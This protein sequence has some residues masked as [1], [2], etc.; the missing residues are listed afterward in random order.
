MRLNKIIIGFTTI[1]FAALIAISAYAAG[2]P[3]SLLQSVADNMIA[4]LKQNQA[5]LKTKPGIVYNLAQQ[6]VVPYANLDE[7]S[8]RVLPRQTWNS[9][10]PAQKAE[11]KKNFT[12]TLIRTYASALSSYKDQTIKFYP[13]RGGAHGNIVTVESQIISNDREPIHVSYQ[14]M[15]TGSGWRLV[16]LSVEGVDMLASF[17]SQFADILSHGSM[18]QLLQ[19]MSKHNSRN[20]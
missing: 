11:F 8:R 2:D 16:D 10:T 1:C 7:M 5:T 4:G 6:Y 18:D 19:R 15:R 12:R 14:M 9:A 13:V 20:G 17:R 3:V